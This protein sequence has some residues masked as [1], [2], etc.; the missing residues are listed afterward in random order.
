MIGERRDVRR[1]RLFA[2]LLTLVLVG[3]PFAVASR[4]LVSGVVRVQP[5]DQPG[6][7][8]HGRVVDRMRSP[9]ADEE[10][11]VFVVARDR[12]PVSVGVFRTDAEG[13]FA[14]DVPPA[15]GVYRLYAGGG[16]LQRISRDVSLLD[17]ADEA[18]EPEAIEFVLEPGCTLDVRFERAGGGRVG[19]GKLTLQRK[20]AL[21]GLFE[22]P[23]SLTREF[24]SDGVVIDGLAPMTAV[25]FVRF[26]SGFEL[27]FEVELEAGTKVSRFTL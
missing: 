11:E 9:L 14:C 7:A 6:G 21:F 27:A 16:E 3:L 19:E 23:F 4:M 2:V 22:V 1:S 12:E 10:V 24:N 13:R 8:L 20:P 26:A 5:G 25:V 15:H 18:V 17:S